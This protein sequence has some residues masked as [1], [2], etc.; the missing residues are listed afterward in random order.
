MKKALIFLALAVA[1][2]SCQKHEPKPVKTFRAAIRLKVG[3]VYKWKQNGV[4][5]VTVKVTG[6]KD[7]VKSIEGA[8]GYAGSECSYFGFGYMVETREESA[9]ACYMVIGDRGENLAE[10][11]LVFKDPKEDIRI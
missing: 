1:S 6:Q 7:F 2:I 11:V 4:K 8:Q 5:S 3:T 9:E 10:G